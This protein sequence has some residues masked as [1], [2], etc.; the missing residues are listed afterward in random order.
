MKGWG[1]HTGLWSWHWT[2]EEA[3]R[4]ISEV[5]NSGL[6][7]EVLE[8]LTLDHPNIDTGHTRSLIEPL[9]VPVVCTLGLP[10]EAA[11]SRYPDRAADFLKSALDTAKSIGGVALTGLTYG[12][13]GE[14]TGAR[15]SQ[16]EMDNVARA[17]DKASA[18]ARTLGMEVGL[19][20][21]NRYES[22]LINTA[23]QAR[24]LIERIGAPN[25]FVHLDTYHVCIEEK[26]AAR[27]VEDAGEHLKYIHLSESTRGM[28][29]EGVCDF[30]G[31]FKTLKDSGFD[32]G[33]IPEAFCDIPHD[34]AGA[35]CIWRDV[36]PSTDEI[37]ERG[38]PYLLEKAKA[39][40]LV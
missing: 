32:G 4:A 12:P 30:D 38:I 16:R 6:P 10:A 23:A 27:A 5:R 1:I 22:H 25:M 36:S 13:I 39:A 24:D 33:L 21:V 9:N 2:R 7:C 3:D 14:R 11:A 40:G 28:P 17:L 19:E 29:G 35:L 37:M 18:H 31:L 15:P 20:V 34:I 8:I 26:S